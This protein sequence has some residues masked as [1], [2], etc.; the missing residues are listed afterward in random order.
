LLVVM[1]GVHH[2]FSLPYG[3]T[4]I[5]LTAALK[6]LFWPITAAQTRM[7]KRMA[8]LQPQIKA[9]QEKY[10][11]DP[12]KAQK[13]VMEFWKEN[14]INPAAGCLPVFIQMP[15]F[16]GFFVMIRS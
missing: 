9:I 3:W 6:L 7:S 11:D 16:I 12:M 5:F 14:K 10:K 1:N 8:V 4:I 15:V 13:K 2:L